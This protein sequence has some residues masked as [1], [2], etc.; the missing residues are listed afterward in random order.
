MAVFSSLRLKKVRWRRPPGSSARRS[1]PRFRLGLV[2]R[3]AHPRRHDRHAVV[4]GQLQIGGIEIRLVAV[5]LAHAAAQ[6]VRDQNGWSPIEVR[7]GPH[8]RADPV[9]QALRPG[10]LGVGVVGGPEHRH[11]DLRGAD[12]PA[13]RIDDLHRLPGVVDEQLLPG[14]VGLAHHHVERPAPGLVALAEPAVAEA[15]GMRGPV[16][17]PQQHQRHAGTAQLLMH[18]RPVRHHAG[19]GRHRRWRRKQPP[20]QLPIAQGLGQGPTQPRGGKAPL[21][22]PDAAA[23]HLQARRDL[24]VRQAG[25]EP[26]AQIL[27]NLTHGQPLHLDPSLRKRGRS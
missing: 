16:L 17:L 27:A 9:G 24:P 5:R 4:V 21:V 26:Q 7:E 1:A 6:I 22:L 20:L 10:R 18:R 19:V 15:L 14:A 25:L 3:L 12:L 13:G 23:R 11:E 2:A 8:M